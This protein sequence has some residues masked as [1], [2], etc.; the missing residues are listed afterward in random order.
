MPYNKNSGCPIVAAQ[1]NGSKTVH[2]CGTA[3]LDNGTINCGNFKSVNIPSGTAIPGV[4]GLS[5]K[6]LGGSNPGNTS[7]PVSSYGRPS[8]SHET[9]IGVRVGVP[10]VVIALASIAWALWERRARFKA[11]STVGNKPMNQHPTLGGF[12]QPGVSCRPVE[13]GGSN[14]S[15][16][17]TGDNHKPPS[18]HQA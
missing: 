6:S 10:L 17:G 14:I 15:E 8:P 12:H 3:T 16:L 1:Y 9:I 18:E 7:T 11:L 13:L 4:A 2:C 5:V